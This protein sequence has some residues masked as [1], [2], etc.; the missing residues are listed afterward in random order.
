MMKMGVARKGIQAMGC[1]L[2]KEHHVVGTWGNISLRLDDPGLVAITPSG[3]AYDTMSVTDIP[4]LN[5]A[6]EVIDGERKPSI[7]WPLHLAIYKAR[8][9]VKAIIHT[10]SPYLTAF[11]IARHELPPSAEDL[12]QI[13][14]GGIRVTDYVLPGSE[15]LGR[16]AVKALEGRNGV[17]LA[18]HGALACGPSLEETFKIVAVMEKSAMA[19]LLSYQLGGPVSLTESDVDAMRDF[20]LHKYGQR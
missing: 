13:C 1:K 15:G 17:I 12:V 9:D 6:G 8:P 10:H 7:E 2:L 4:V 3:M 16:E 18:N 11:A 14:G 5:L 19:T 20:Y